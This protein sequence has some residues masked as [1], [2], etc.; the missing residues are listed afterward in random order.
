MSE[1]SVAFIYFYNKK[2]V[3]RSKVINRGKANKK[4]IFS[5]LIKMKYI[6]LK[7]KLMSVNFKFEWNKV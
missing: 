7:P 6:I 3:L 4:L 5:D 1:I 2:L